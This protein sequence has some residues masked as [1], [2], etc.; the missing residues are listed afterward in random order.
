MRN[1]LLTPALATGV[2][3]NLTSLQDTLSNLERICNTPLPFA[4]QAHL[5][6]SLWS[7]H[8]L[9]QTDRELLLIACVLCE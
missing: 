2:T 4:Y 3:G 1:A 7:V 5:R 9:T 8:N 6:M